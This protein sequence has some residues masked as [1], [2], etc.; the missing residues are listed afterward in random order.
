MSFWYHRK[1]ECNMQMVH[2]HIAYTACTTCF[3]VF[4]SKWLTS[5]F[6][7]LRLGP[8][9][10]M[11]PS[12]FLCSLCLLRTSITSWIRHSSF[13]VRTCCW[14]GGSVC[15]NSEKILGQNWAR[16]MSQIGSIIDWRISAGS[17]TFT[18][19]QRDRLCDTVLDKELPM[20]PLGPHFLISK[21][22]ESGWDKNKRGKTK[23]SCITPLINLSS[24]N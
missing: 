16:Q 23:D 10:V 15:E 24:P 19:C 12:V 18:V 8:Y 17:S 11:E 13:W 5:V 14:L 7:M 4:F 2:L 3:N 22:T 9:K 21:W 6:C 20:L 1:L